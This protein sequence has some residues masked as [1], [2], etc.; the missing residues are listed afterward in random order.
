MRDKT[1]ICYCAGGLGNRLKPMASCWAISRL[2]GRR[3]KILWRKDD[4]RRQVGFA[5]VGKLV[6]WSMNLDH[7]LISTSIDPNLYYS[8]EKK[9][10]S[11]VYIQRKAA[12]IKPLRRLLG[13]HN[14]A[15]LQQLQ[16]QPLFN[17]PQAVY[18]ENIR[19]ASVFLNLSP[20]EGFPSSCV[21]AMQCETLVAGFDAVGGQQILQNGN[22]S[23]LAPNAD[24]PALAY[25]LSPVLSDLL[26]GSFDTWQPLLEN[27]KNLT[28][29]YTLEAEAESLIRF[30]Q[31]VL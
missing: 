7:H 20:A 24:Y 8:P 26:T 17:L 31:S 22:N 21:E 15:Y 6:S 10:R 13:A 1:I 14:K 30:W 23:L 11:I 2:T 27:A 29:S 19:N 25:A 28:A 12:C 4:L 18:A 9:E 5:L 16:W 3:L